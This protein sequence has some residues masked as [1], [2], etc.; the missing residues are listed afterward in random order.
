MRPTEYC[1]SLF[2]RIECEALPPGWYTIVSYGFGQGYE[3]NFDFRESAINAGYN[4]C[5]NVPTGLASMNYGSQITI[6]LDTI[7]SPGP[8][9]YKPSLAYVPPSIISYDNI[10]GI[11]YPTPFTEYELGEEYFKDS[12]YESVVN[13]EI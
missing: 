4:G 11:D 1:Q 2:E 5:G 3:N 10:G 7:A 8:F 6:Q 9:Y 13:G 12:I